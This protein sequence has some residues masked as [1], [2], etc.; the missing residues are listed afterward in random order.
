[1]VFI[2]RHYNYTNTSKNIFTHA[3]CVQAFF[4]IM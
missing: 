3:N 1:M 2:Y 4:R